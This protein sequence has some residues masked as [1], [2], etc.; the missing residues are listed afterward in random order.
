MCVSIAS[1]IVLSHEKN[2][3][4]LTQFLLL[5]K[6]IYFYIPYDA[7]VAYDTHYK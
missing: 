5:L 7:V 4:F 2:T 6:V 1:S 3:R